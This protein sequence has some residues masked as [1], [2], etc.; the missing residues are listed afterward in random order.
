MIPI[1][2]VGTIIS[3]EIQVIIWKIANKVEVGHQAAPEGRAPVNEAV[4]WTQTHDGIFTEVCCS[5][6]T[7][8][9]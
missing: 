2:V 7:F 3:H 1:L 5:F 9:D 4:F 6:E 8:I